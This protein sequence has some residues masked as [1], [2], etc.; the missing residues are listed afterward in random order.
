MKSSIRIKLRTMAA[1]EDGS[2]P[3]RSVF[4]TGYS[5]FFNVVIAAKKE[6]KFERIITGSEK[7]SV[8]RICG[9]VR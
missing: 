2:D 7:L 8:S 1:K 4:D 9:K 5:W 6:K 3:R